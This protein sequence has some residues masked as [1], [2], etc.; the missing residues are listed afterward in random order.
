MSLAIVGCSGGLK[1][2]F[3]Q[4]VLNGL[5]AGGLR[6]D[7]YA[8]ASASAVPAACAAAGLCNA[9]G[10]GYTAKLI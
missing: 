8:G 3:I 4:G 5:E 2:V 1:A 7:A 6:A 9:Q 10:I